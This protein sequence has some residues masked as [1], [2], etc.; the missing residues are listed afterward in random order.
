MRFDAAASKQPQRANAAYLW[1]IVD[2]LVRDWRRRRSTRHS[3]FDDDAEAKALHVANPE[4]TPEALAIAR[5][6]Q[7]AV[8]RALRRLPPRM[9]RAV[10]MHRLEGSTLKQIATGLGVSVT[11]AHTLV[12]DGLARCRAAIS[13]RN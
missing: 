11:T 8:V 10:E 9:R 7:R 13:E 4:P 5:D 1:T 3:V 6:E 12:A 2:N